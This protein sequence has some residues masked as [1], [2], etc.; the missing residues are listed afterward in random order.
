VLSSAVVFVSREVEA[1]E[2]FRC[3]V[4]NFGS[5]GVVPRREP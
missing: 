5:W 4:V 3:G 2:S 1:R